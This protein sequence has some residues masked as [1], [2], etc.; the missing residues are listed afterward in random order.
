MASRAISGK[1]GGGK[2]YYAT[3]LLCEELLNTERHIVTN[4][5]LIESGIADYLQKKG[6][7]DIDVFSR[8]TRLDVPKSEE[9]AKVSAFWRYRGGGVILPEIS[10]SDIKSGVRPDVSLFGNGVHYFLDELHKFLNSRQWANTGPLLLWYI[11][12]H[13]HFGDDVTWVTQHV[14]NVDKQWRSVTQ[15][16]TYCRNHAV[17]KF[18]G[19]RKDSNFHI[20]TYLEP[21]TGNQ[22][23]QESKTLKPDWEGIGKCY[24][25]SIAHGVADKGK[26]AKGWPVWILY[27]G[28]IL[29]CI[30]VALGFMF[31]PGWL[32]DRAGKK[33]EAS[34]KKLQEKFVV[35]A[36]VGGVMGKSRNPGSAPLD[37]PPLVSEIFNVAV[38]LRNITREEA[39]LSL[40]KGGGTSSAGGSVVI[41]PAPFGNGLVLSG[42]NFQQI[43]SFAEKLKLLDSAS[44]EMVMV[45]GVVLR[46]VKGRSSGIGI[47][48]IL[49][50]IVKEGGLGAGDISFDFVTGIV[51]VGSIQAAQD[52]LR[53]L[54]SQSVGRNSLLVE[55]RPILATVSGKTAWF[56]SGQEIPVPV[57]T[58]NVS[59]SQTSIQ[60]KS[61][62]F[63]LGV[64]PFVLPGG[65]SVSVN[66]S[67]GDVLGDTVISG[68]SVPSIAT[69]SLT[70]ELFLQEGQVA[71]LGGI[72]V[73]NKKDN[74]SGFPVFSAV[75][76]FSWVFGRR[77][78]EQ[79][80]SEIVVLLTVFRV[81]SGANPLPVRKGEPVKKISD[82]KETARI[83]NP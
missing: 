1:P 26:K 5:E 47:W 40:E 6:R 60:Y 73:V 35:P 72:Q 75:P 55:S 17:E 45:Q 52:L 12:Q 14:P 54:G 25:T 80:E 46:T 44:P 15:D 61:V 42:S 36:A 69:Q 53:I 83:G 41:H 10:E 67:N 28:I 50:E 13:R 24:D 63:A 49:Q 43:S 68:N 81:P 29:I 11:S 33:A 48:N 58:A 65:I 64:T 34:A 27:A 22:T 7:G 59:S 31:V 78:K 51:S 3:Y 21:F 4:L 62:S 30:L 57:T 37:T 79:K 39:I 74:S 82:K 23:L 8:I 38:Q 19:F 77:E 32:G 70:T 2:S 20:E 66:Q 56:A 9:S 16:Y 18:R 76:P 71:V